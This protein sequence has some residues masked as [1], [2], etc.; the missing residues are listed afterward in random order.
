MGNVM[1]RK[2]P[3]PVN[4]LSAAEFEAMFPD[5]DA[6]CTYLVARRWPYGVRCPRCGAEN[7]HKRQTEPWTWQC[8]KCAPQTSYRFSHLAGTIFENTKKPLRDWYKVVHLMLAS[9]VDHLMLASKKGTSPLQ[10]MRVMGFGSYKTAWRMCRKIR[11]ALTEDIDKLGGVVEF[12]GTFVGGKVKNRGQARPGGTGAAG[13]D[14]L[15]A[16]GGRGAQA[17]Q[18]MR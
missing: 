18:K 12:D 14:R 1:T 10:I 13:R 5:E 7:P 11:G 8:Y 16:I 9:K 15:A 6:C 17:P 2:Q 4:Q 3:K